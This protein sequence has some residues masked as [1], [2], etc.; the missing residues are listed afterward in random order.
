M[1]V[2]VHVAV[3]EEVE[4][5]G[6]AMPQMQR[7]GRAAV[8]HEVL[9]DATKLVPESALCRRQDIEAGAEYLGHLLAASLPR[10]RAQSEAVE[11]CVRPLSFQT[12][13][14]TAWCGSAAACP[15][16]GWSPPGPARRCPWRPS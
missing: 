9:G 10:T 12:P 2:G 15:W 16:R 11:D 7:K 6:L 13:D 1:L 14:P 8:Q 3:G 4:V 5:L